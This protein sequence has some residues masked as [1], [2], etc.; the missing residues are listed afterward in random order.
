MVVKEKLKA[1][2]YIHSACPEFKALQELRYENMKILEVKLEA[3]IHGKDKR[4]EVV[5]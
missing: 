2:K 3:L 4:I 5:R 1:R